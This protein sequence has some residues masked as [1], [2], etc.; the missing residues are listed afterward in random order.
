MPEKEPNIKRQKT[1]KSTGNE[2]S[3]YFRR[4]GYLV[5]ATITFLVILL[6]SS[7]F[8]EK[9]K[10]RN[11]ELI[12]L[13][14]LKCGPNLL[15]PSRYTEEKFITLRG[16]RESKNV[17]K[18]VEM[19]SEY[20][21]ISDDFSDW[22]EGYGFEWQAR[23][24]IVTRD[25]YSTEKKLDERSIEIVSIDRKTLKREFKKF[26]DNTMVDKSTRQCEEISIG[27]YSSQLENVKALFLKGNKI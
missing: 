7:V 19:I 8:Y 23:D 4:V 22:K 14:A 16:T 24:V 21:V 15:E 17:S 3:L 11:T 5:I 1:K 26:V 6:G 18:L 27:E 9:Y 10:D 13:V 20:R 25:H 2:A 12:I